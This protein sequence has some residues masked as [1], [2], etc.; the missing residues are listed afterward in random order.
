VPDRVVIRASRR[1]LP[2]PVIGSRGKQ[3]YDVI[4]F[5]AWRTGTPDSVLRNH[6]FCL[7]RERDS[8]AVALDMCWRSCMSEGGPAGRSGGRIYMAEIRRGCWLWFYCPIGSSAETIGLSEST[9]SKRIM[10]FPPSSACNLRRIDRQ[11]LASRIKG[12]KGLRVAVKWDLKR[13]G[14]F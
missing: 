2:M 13:H 11:S 12:K 10:D 5:R 3:V 8:V 1:S 14:S 7:K 4:V 6:H 9:S